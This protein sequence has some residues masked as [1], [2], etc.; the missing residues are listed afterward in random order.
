M[1]NNVSM[2]MNSLLVVAFLVSA[3]VLGMAQTSK[4]KK[5]T[6]SSKKILFVVTSHDKKGSTGQPT[7]YYLGEVSHP[8]EVLHEA[9]YEIDFVSPK[10]GKAPVDG[11]DLKDA[12]NQKFWENAKY[13]AKVENTLTPAQVKPSEYA[14]IF[15]AGG[16]GAVWDF[17][18]NEELAKIA[19]QI[20]ENQGVV[21]AVCHGPAALVGIK[22]SNGKYLVEG[23][24]INAFTNEEE[25]AV[26]LAD[27]VPFLLESKLIERG[28]KF[29]K[30]GLWQPHV[31]ADQRVITGQNP[32]SAKGVGEA[33]LKELSK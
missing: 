13:H 6:K 11:F 23:K 9:G 15:F 2:L 28:A 32:A 25:T 21:S 27:V 4:A 26:G 7:G 19:A 31:V 17:P 3:S 12:T 29:E 8:W 33:L 22:L 14:A 18:Q 16:H 30:S 10:G 5:M 24:K 20:Y 1:K